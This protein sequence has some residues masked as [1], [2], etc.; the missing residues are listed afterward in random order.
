MTLVVSI[1]RF[2]ARVDFEQIFTKRKDK[3]L[4]A[5]YFLNDKRKQFFLQA[6]FCGNSEKAKKRKIKS[7]L[8]KKSSKSCPPI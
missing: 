4:H 6:F 8:F 2:F 3:K 5:I 7:L 1:S